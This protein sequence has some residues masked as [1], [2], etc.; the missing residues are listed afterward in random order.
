MGI[1][2]Y[3]GNTN[4][5][6]RINIKYS[7]KKPKVRFSYP[8]PDKNNPVRGSMFQYIFLIWVI[9][10]LIVISFWVGGFNQGILSYGKDNLQL[11]SECSAKNYLITLTNY[12]R[13]EEEICNQFIDKSNFRKK[14]AKSILL[15]LFLVFI[16]P[17]LIYYPFKKKWDAFYP[18]FNALHSEKKIRTFKGKDIIEDENGI[19]VELPIFNNVICDYKAIGDFSKNLREF[20]IREHKFHYLK[21]TKIGKRRIKKYNEFIW[22]S[23]WYFNKKPKKGY[24]KV[25]FK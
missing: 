16:P 13:I 18:E 11:Y 5:N 17:F 2:R 1:D 19:Y 15:K 14:Y 12:S 3:N 4:K 22:Y 21:K 8:I 23:R 10:S 24:L 20:E 7:G 9:L 6:A 25:I